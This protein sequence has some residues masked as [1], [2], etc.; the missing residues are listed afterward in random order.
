MLAIAPAFALPVAEMAL[1][2]EGGLVRGV[3]KPTFY[4]PPP[5]SP[6]RDAAAALWKRVVISL[7]S[8]A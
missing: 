3:L 5:G 2:L 7:S 8:A 1:A 6:D 4:L